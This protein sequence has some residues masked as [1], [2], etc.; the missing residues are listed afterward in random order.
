[1][2]TIILRVISRQFDDAYCLYTPTTESIHLSKYQLPCGHH[3]VLICRFVVS[4]LSFRSG[5]PGELS[6]HSIQITF[7]DV[8]DVL[9]NFT[10]YTGHSVDGVFVF[11]TQFKVRS[12]RIIIIIMVV[13]QAIHIPMIH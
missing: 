7:L 11:W 6:R 5:P 8:G 9:K 3:Q 12:L 10:I 13:K 2:R 4:F 1:M